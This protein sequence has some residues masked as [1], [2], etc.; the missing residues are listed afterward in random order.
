[1]RSANLNRRRRHRGM[2]R[3]EASPMESVANL[4][5]VMLVFI[6]GLI[7]A[8]IVFWNVDLE[9]LDQRTESSYEDVGQVYQDPDTGKVYVIQQNPSDE[10]PGTEGTS[11]GTDDVSGGDSSGGSPQKGSSDEAAE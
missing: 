4:I 11:D 8:I 1:M 10:T 5:D 2:E 3:E 7:I 6:C 9:N